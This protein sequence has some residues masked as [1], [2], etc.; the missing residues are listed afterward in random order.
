MESDLVEYLR[1]GGDTP[2]ADHIFYE[3]CR[4]HGQIWGFGGG[5]GYKI[6][7]IS[8]RILTLYATGWFIVMA[9]T[10]LRQSG[11]W[12]HAGHESPPRG[13]AKTRARSR[14]RSH[15]GSP[16]KATVC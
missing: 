1:D 13:G 10:F 14:V 11:D 7:G 6:P 15:C 16:E 8:C 4:C 9:S 12:P 2:V 5:G 3:E